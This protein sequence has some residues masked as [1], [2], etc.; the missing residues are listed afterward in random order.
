MQMPQAEMKSVYVVLNWHL[1]IYNSAEGILTTSFDTGPC[2]V[3][4]NHVSVLGAQTD[5]GEEGLAEGDGCGL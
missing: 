1:Y 3:S 2:I 5:R 4:L